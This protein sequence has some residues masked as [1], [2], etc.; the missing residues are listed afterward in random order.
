MFPTANPQIMRISF[1][2]WRIETRAESV[3]KNISTA[4]TCFFEAMRLENLL[5]LYVIEHLKSALRKSGTTRPMERS[6]VIPITPLI[7]QF[8]SPPDTPNIDYLRWKCFTLLAFAAMLRTSVIEPNAELYNASI[9]ETETDVLKV[10]N[11]NFTSDGM[12][13]I[14]HCIKNDSQRKG[15]V[16]VNK[17]ADQQV[18][19]VIALRDY[20]NATQHQRNQIKMQCF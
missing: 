9:A 20:I 19:P 3:I 12:S 13:I 1:V 2:W 10:C 7:N 4:R 16:H 17:L 18:C 15:P 8:K 5:E 11:I 6:K 14:F